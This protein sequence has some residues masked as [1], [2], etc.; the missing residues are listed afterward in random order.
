MEDMTLNEIIQKLS[1]GHS[2][3][4]CFNEMISILT[5]WAFSKEALRHKEFKEDSPFI[6]E[7]CDRSEKAILKAGVKFD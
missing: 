1:E 4:K 3:R 6:L 7:L 5:E 2:A